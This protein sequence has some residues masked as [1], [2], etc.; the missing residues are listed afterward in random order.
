[1]MTMMMMMM[2]MMTMVLMMMLVMMMM[3]LLLFLL[4]GLLLPR[5]PQD[6]APQIPNAGLSEICVRQRLRKKGS[7]TE[8]TETGFCPMQAT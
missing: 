3:M 6:T 8:Q 7:R 2:M 1:M 5:S 4:C